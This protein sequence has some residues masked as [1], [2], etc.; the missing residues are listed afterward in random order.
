MRVGLIVPMFERSPASAL[1]VA[2]EADAKGIDGVFCY[3]HLFP[4]NRPDRPALS[5]IPMLA[6]IAMTTQRVM[7]GPLVGRV[8]LLPLPVLLGAFAT[9]D[10]LSG[11]RLIAALGTGDALTK[12][13]NDAY[14]LPFPVLDERLQLL[15]EAARGLRALGVRTWI[16]GRSARVRDLAV[17]EADGWNVW[18]SPLDELAAF[19]GAH[20]EVEVTWAGPPPADDL[21]RHLLSV[22]ATGA[23]WAI[24]GPPPTVAWVGFIDKL[25]EAAEG[26]R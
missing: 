18:D 13:E 2:Q 6:A 7:L 16:G 22:A 11:G 20:P 17:A 24:Y 15:A 9:V 12:P 14:G 25:A 26:V 21:G 23:T 4:I 8:T 5:A 19:A 3:D 1:S 10:Q